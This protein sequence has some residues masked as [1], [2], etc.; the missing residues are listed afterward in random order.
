MSVLF[1]YLLLFCFICGYCFI[2]CLHVCCWCR[3]CWTYTCC[4]HVCIVSRTR[5]ATVIGTNL[6]SGIRSFTKLI[7]NFSSWGSEHL[8]IST[9]P[10]LTLPESL[11]WKTNTSE[12]L[13]VNYKCVYL[14]DVFGWISIYFNLQIVCLWWKAIIIRMVF[15]GWI[16]IYYTSIYWLNNYAILHEQWHQMRG[17]YGSEKKILTL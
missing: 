1:L 3:C 14:H 10:L 5:L 11:I 16:T 7:K 15:L 12:H 8:P 4:G 13:W 17:Q 9:T 6:P 2:F